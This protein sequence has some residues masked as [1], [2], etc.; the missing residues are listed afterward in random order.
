MNAAIRLLLLLSPVKVRNLPP[1]EKKFLVKEDGTTQIISESG[2][3]LLS[4]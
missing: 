2:V 1:P 4:D 3:P